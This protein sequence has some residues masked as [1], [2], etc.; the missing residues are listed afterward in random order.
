MTVG[1]K[2][3]IDWSPIATPIGL[4]RIV[5]ASL[6]E[7]NWVGDDLAA[8]FDWKNGLERTGLPAAID[9]SGGRGKTR[10]GLC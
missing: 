2:L 5:E 4:S 1:P 8:E 6:P 7:A 10:M 3:S 9:F